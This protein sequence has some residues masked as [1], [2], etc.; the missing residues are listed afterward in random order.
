VDELRR[1]DR[2]AAWTLV[3]NIVNAVP[4]LLELALL[5]KFGLSIWGEF[6]AAQAVVMVGGRVSCLGLDKSMLWYLPG[7]AREGRGIRRPAW[8]AALIAAL[9]GSAAAMLFAWPLL[10]WVLPRETELGLARLVVLAIPFFCAS[11]VFIGALQGV[12]K[13]HYRPLLR[14]LGASAF[15]APVALGLSLFFSVGPISLGMGFLAGHFT[16]ALLS[17]WFWSRESR[18]SKHG[19]LVPT[20]ALVRYTGPVW[21]ADSVNS[22]GMRATVLM[23]SRVAAPGVVGAFGVMQSIL[24]TTSLARRAFETPLVTLVASIRNSLPEVSVLYRKVVHR[25]LLWQTPLVLAVASAGG[26]I[27][28]LIS[29]HLGGDREHWGLL[30]MIACYFIATGPALGQQVLAGLGNS[31]RLL[32]NNLFGTTATISFV[33]IL[34]PRWGLLGASAAQG[35]STLATASVG[36]Y[37]LRKHAKLPGFPGSYRTVVATTLLFAALSAVA[38]TFFSRSGFPWPAWVL[39]VVGIGTWGWFAPRRLRA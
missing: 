3:G 5:R 31:P 11:E 4:A 36:A 37:Q 35:L 39:G 23:L 14:D 15:F 33:W 12:Q 20:R 10:R 16:I 34:T 9:V 26:T 13:F 22:A 18:D 28:H 29:P 8:G 19:P 7:M 6:L 38:W 21:L 24:E 17:A 27:L 30:C 1:I 2:G 25:A 32:F